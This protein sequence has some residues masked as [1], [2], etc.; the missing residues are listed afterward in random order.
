M[1]SDSST[2]SS[3]AGRPAP[4]TEKKTPEIFHSEKPPDLSPGPSLKEDICSRP[5]TETGA[6]TIRGARWVLVVLAIAMTAFLYGLDTSIAADVQGPVV[7]L[8]GEVEKLAW[9]G[10]GFPLGS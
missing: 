8:F 7:E 10:D 4:A 9:I 5:T 1:D 6:Q 3:L 2:T